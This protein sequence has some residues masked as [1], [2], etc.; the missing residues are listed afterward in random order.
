MYDCNLAKEVMSDGIYIYISI[1]VPWE[2]KWCQ[3]PGVRCVGAEEVENVNTL[4]DDAGVEIE[5]QD[6]GQG[7]KLYNVGAHSLR[8]EEKQQSEDNHDVGDP[9]PSLTIH[10]EPQIEDIL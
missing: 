2:R 10:E 4:G 7:D 3:I 9:D 1:I 6:Q 5:L 8:I